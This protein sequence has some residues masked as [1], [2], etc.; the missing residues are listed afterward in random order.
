MI[1]PAHYVGFYGA[2]LSAVVPTPEYGYS[3]EIH[4]PIS[5]STSDDGTHSA[6]DAATAGTYDYRVLTMSTWYLTEAQKSEL[7]AVLH[8]VTD[9]RCENF[10]MDLGS[11]P[12]GFFPF[13]PDKG[14]YGEFTV[15]LLSQ[16]QSG[17]LT[18]PQ[19]YFKD[20][21]SFV[22]VTAPA[23][24]PPAHRVEGGLTIGSVS[25]VRFPDGGITPR[26]MY[27]YET[28]LSL[29]GAPLSLDGPAEA[30]GFEADAVLIAGQ[31]KASELVEF[32]IAN[33]TTIFTLTTPA[34]YYFYGYD[35]G[36]SGSYST[37]FMGSE[38]DER[39]I[40]L[41]ITHDRFDQFTMPVKF[42]LQAKL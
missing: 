19:Y 15:R 32:F 20:T 34:K 8:S 38:I 13:G 17:C 12:T 23:Y 9:G 35:Q 11:T 36:S 27:K 30:T 10:Y 5:I 28:D 31:S 29:S 24:T 1:V 3:V 16:D 18:A 37:M 39:E 42:W 4:M 14:D 22:L 21:L 41:M 2:T 7:N 6:W 40:V 25:N 33:R 26:T